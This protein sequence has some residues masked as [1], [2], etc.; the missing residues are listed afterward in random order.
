MWGRALYSGEKNYILYCLYV[1]ENRD[2]IRNNLNTVVGTIETSL[3]SPHMGWIDLHYLP[4]RVFIEAYSTIFL[5]VQF[6]RT[7][8]LLR[9][10]EG[11]T[12]R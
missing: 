3:L 11:L 2:Y 7:F 10:P 5:Y 8:A 9:S 1:E 6:C 12:Q 4:F